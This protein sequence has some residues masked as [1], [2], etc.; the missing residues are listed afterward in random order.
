M[1]RR[2]AESDPTDCGAEQE[3]IVEHPLGPRVLGVTRAWVTE[4]QEAHTETV[5]ILRDITDEKRLA[6]ERAAAR[7]TNALAEIATLLAHEIRNPLGSLEMFTGLLA[8]ATEEQPEARQWVNHLQAGLRSLSATV[9]N[10]LQF[11]SRPNTVRVPTDLDRLLRETA[12]F[13]TPLARQ[14][15]MQIVLE[16]DLGRITIG[17]DPH[18]LQQVFYNLALNAF[19]SMTPGGYLTIRV[20]AAQESPVPGV[21]IEFEDEGV[22]IAEENLDRI[23]EPGFTTNAGS[24]G[25]GLSVCKK[26]M[27]QHGGEIRVR[28]VRQ[29][30]S[31]FTAVLPLS[32]GTE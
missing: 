29:H 19:R 28:S 12:E 10:V 6:E 7:R 13:L 24:P 17:V 8:D 5:W 15:G 9:N 1:E 20:S 27:E 30:G 4:P 18:C 26:V 31:T 21:R 3:W 22:G 11:H 2:F 16:N 14:R 32:G 25:L 23:F